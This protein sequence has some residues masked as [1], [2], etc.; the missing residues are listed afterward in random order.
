MAEFAS[1][2]ANVGAANTPERVAAA[3]LRT[4]AEQ[5]CAATRA[6][7]DLS[8]LG[9]AADIAATHLGVKAKLT[10]LAQSEQDRRAADRNAAETALFGLPRSPLS[11]ADA[12]SQRDAADRAAALATPDSAAALLDRAQ[13]GNDQ[14]LASAVAQRA[15]QDGWRG[16]LAQY[17]GDNQGKQD[18]LDVISEHKATVGTTAD[19][20]TRDMIFRGGTPPEVKGMSPQKVK[21]L[22]DQSGLIE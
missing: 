12:V 17:V 21:A 3:R 7:T 4:T 11:G 20:L 22:A 5:Q 9:K 14:H 6:R 2:N 8:D 1:N 13:R 16:V 18:A 10:D 19:K 15:A